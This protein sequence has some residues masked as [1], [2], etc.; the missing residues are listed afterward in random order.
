MSGK[1]NTNTN[2]SDANIEDTNADQVTDFANNK[3]YMIFTCAFN[4]IV[5][6]L[7]GKSLKGKVVG[8]VAG[9]GDT[10]SWNLITVGKNTYSIQNVYAWAGLNSY[11]N[12]TDAKVGAGLIGNLT[13]RT[14]EIVKV[15]DSIYRIKV[16]GA[17]LFWTLTQ[18]TQP[19]QAPTQIQLL[20]D[21]GDADQY[22]MFKNSD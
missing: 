17:D 12:V 20:P 3:P 18:N 22:W 13:P 9:G 8:N 6:D 4:F 5:A 11:A 1:D 21:S 14:W 19:P 7:Y 2:T 15:R 10:Q 16:P